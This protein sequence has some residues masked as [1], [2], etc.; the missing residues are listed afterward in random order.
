MIRYR[1]I[2]ETCGSFGC[3]GQFTRDVPHGQSRR[4]RPTPKER[5][6][7]PS[8]PCIVTGPISASGKT[9]IGGLPQKINRDRFG[10]TAVSWATRLIE[11]GVCGFDQI[12]CFRRKGFRLDRG[13][14]RNWRRSLG[15]Q[16]SDE[17]AR[18]ALSIRPSITVVV[19]PFPHCSIPARLFRLIATSIPCPDFR[20]PGHLQSL[21]AW[22]CELFGNSYVGSV[23]G[24]LA[25]FGCWDFM[26]SSSSF[27]DPP[28]D[29]RST[30]HDAR[31]RET[32]G[33]WA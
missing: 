33:P 22:S 19:W 28:T 4:P 17:T 30:F 6:R 21:P 27:R 13:T 14:R 8:P 18:S 11:R 5:R 3:R 23:E 26:A 7:G 9:M 16:W 24:I 12:G 1:A 15:R 29:R 20:K 10:I 25:K 2:S 32:S 31:H